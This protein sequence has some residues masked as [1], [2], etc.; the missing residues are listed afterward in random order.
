MPSLTE[1]IQPATWMVVITSATITKSERI[2]IASAF[3]MIGTYFGPMDGPIAGRKMAPYRNHGM[4]KP[5]KMSKILEPM[6]E[7]TAMSPWPRRATAIDERQ[8]GM[9]VPAARS[10]TP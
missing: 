4:G 5:I 7:E 10:V 6:N 3:E 9:D 8:S 1:R 2:M